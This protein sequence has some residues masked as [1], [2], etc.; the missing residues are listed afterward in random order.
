MPRDGQ[1]SP[2]PPPW[3]EPG[4]IRLLAQRAAAAQ[5]TGA[6]R[7]AIERAC[8]DRARVLRP[9]WPE[10]WITEAASIALWVGDADSA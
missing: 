10:P 2:S 4:P 5:A 3:L 8:H 6:P 7:A 9:S 1:P